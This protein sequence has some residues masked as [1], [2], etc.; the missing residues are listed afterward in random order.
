M[1]SLRLQVLSLTHAPLALVTKAAPVLSEDAYL[2][3]MP[4]AWELLI[5]CDQ[6]LAAAAGKTSY[7]PCSVCS[8]KVIVS[9]SELGLD[10]NLITQ[11]NDGFF[12]RNSTV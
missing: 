3:M 1:F 7:L 5:E 11:R 2:D 10:V 9:I 8:I 12:Y 4:V 6:E